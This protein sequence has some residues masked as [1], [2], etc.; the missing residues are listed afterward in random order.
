MIENELVED[1]VVSGNG[2]GYWL[3]WYVVGFLI[4]CVLNSLILLL[5]IIGVMVYI[6]SSWFEIIVLVVI[7]LCLN[8]VNFMKVGKCLVLYGLGV[9]MI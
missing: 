9:G 2:N 1:V 8:F 3:L 5:V 7:G 4:L 6:I